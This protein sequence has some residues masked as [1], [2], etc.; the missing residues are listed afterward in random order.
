M[1]PHAFGCCKHLQIAFGDLLPFRVM[2]EVDQAENSA[3]TR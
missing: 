3:L 1:V 2:I